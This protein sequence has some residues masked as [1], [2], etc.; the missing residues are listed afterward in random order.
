M[1][2]RIRVEVKAAPIRTEVKSK[3]I[4]VRVSAAQGA[5]GADGEQGLNGTDGLS[6]YQV[7]LANGFVG[8]ENDWL[9]SLIGPQGSP[10]NDGQNGSDASVTEAN[11]VTALS[12]VASY[13]TVNDDD[14]IWLEN[15]AKSAG[16]WVPWLTGIVEKL[17]S[18][19]VHLTGGQTIQS[20]AA[21]VK[22][23][24]LKGAVSQT[25]NLLEVQ[26]NAGSNLLTIDKNGKITSNGQGQFGALSLNDV[27][28]KEHIIYNPM[29]G[30]NSSGAQVSGVVGSGSTNVGMYLDSSS[31]ANSSAKLY[32]FGPS[33]NQW[34]TPQG[35]SM[36]QGLTFTRRFRIAFTLG[37]RSITNNGRYL[38]LIGSDA[39]VAATAQSYVPVVKCFGIEIVGT[40][41]RA[42]AYNTGIITGTTY[43]V[44]SGTSYDILL[45]VFN[46]VANVYVN[47]ILASTLSGC[48]TSISVVN[49]YSL[50]IEASCTATNNRFICSHGNLRYLITDN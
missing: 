2:D 16:K 18:A 48:P 10:G 6:A 14:V 1:A 49:N 23:L 3:K 20:S 42:Y 5:K 38:M 8:N 12:G 24:I 45:D 32:W 28:I 44:A 17:K 7:A 13:N 41:L 4:S 27:V 35:P 11:I 15:S 47:G 25:A 9:N 40:T 34:F 22:G 31:V 46:G 37:I 50:F 30:I 33:F 26:N 39:A 21:G 43:T 19:F 36:D 29:Y